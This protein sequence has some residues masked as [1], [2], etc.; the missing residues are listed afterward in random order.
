M[1]VWIGTSGYSY[2][3][4]VGA[5]Y[6]PGTRSDRM[7]SYYCRVFP[8]V[9]LNFTFYRLPTPAM[10]ARLADSTPEGFLF[11][12]KLPRA[13]SHEQRADDLAAFRE[14]AAELQRRK[15]LMSLLCQMP[16]SAHYDKK[17]LQWLQFLGAE[18]SDMR[19]AVEVRHRSWQQEDLS[20]WL[21]EHHL[22]LVS[23]DVP[24]IP[25]LFPRAWVQSSSRAYVRLHS[26]CAE[27]WYGG[28]KKRYDYNYSDAELNEWIEWMNAAKERTEETLFLFNNCYRGQAVANAQRLRR[29]IEERMPLSVV[30]PFAAAPPQQR[31][32]FE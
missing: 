18:L 7:L 21:A 3:D 14:A 19:L 13:L 11:T 26:R 23:V 25:A 9:E 31:S 32:L 8:L 28:D 2:P 22:D 12:V 20:Q 29:L 17:N 27:N 15:R 16:Q 5:F 24:D 4:W 6:P 1:K 10:L 30:P